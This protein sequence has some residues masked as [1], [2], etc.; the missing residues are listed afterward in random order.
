MLAGVTAPFTDAVALVKNSADPT[1]LFTISNSG[2]TT[3]NNITLNL[4]GTSTAPIYSIGAAGI[5]QF[6]GNSIGYTNGV[7]PIFGDIS[8]GDNIQFSFSGL[9]VGRTYAWPNIGGTV[10]VAATTGSATTVL[11][12]GLPGNFGSVVSA[13]LNITPTT[14][15]NQFIRSIAGS[16]VGTCASIANADTGSVSVIGKVTL[17]Q[18]ATGSTLT[19]I[20][21]K[22]ATFNNTMTMAGTDGTTMTFPSTSASIARIDTGQAFTGNNTNSGDFTLGATS[23]LGWGSSGVSTPDTFLVRDGAANT[24]ALKNST[25]AQKLSI[26]NTDD[27]AGNFERASLFFSSNVLLLQTSQGGTGTARNMQVG[28]TGVASVC[29]QA[30]GSCRLTIDSSGNPSFTAP[31]PA[32]SGGTGQSSYTQGDL[33]YASASNA[34]SKLADVAAGSY[35]RSGG[36]GA[37]PVYS[38][39]TLP[40]TAS[41]GTALWATT[42]NTVIAVAPALAHANPANQTGNATATF[43]MNGLGAAAAPCTI[44]PVATGRVIFTITGQLAQTTTADGVTTKLAFGTGAAPANA[45][46]ATGTVISATITHTALTGALEVPFA[47]TASTTGLALSTAVW[48]DLQL[49]NVTGGT[50]SITNVDCTAWEM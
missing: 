32:A 11:H 16:G 21:G 20:D 3:G 13:D 46:A 2:I 50:A 4:K 44:T 42:S 10:V 41:A 24:L 9:S 25:S 49:A 39:L 7:G 38:T 35:V 30:A 26:Y 19:I 37:N 8:V 12:G 17:T 1:K 14:C 28:P 33:L 5:V 18:P 36:V 48:F 27:G 40:N 31:V 34:L 22:T 15:T 23:K 29:L 45:A 47:I 6:G 43:K